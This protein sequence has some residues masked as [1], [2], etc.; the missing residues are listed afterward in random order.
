MDLAKSKE[1]KTI[2]QKYINLLL[3]TPK[4]RKNNNPYYSNKKN[5][6]KKNFIINNYNNFNYSNNKSQHQYKC[7][8]IIIHKANQ[9]QV[10]SLIRSIYIYYIKNKNK[11]NNFYYFIKYPRYRNQKNE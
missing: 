10:K 2:I 4:K 7:S 1:T 8:R 11:G 6:A 3:N 9:N 5:T